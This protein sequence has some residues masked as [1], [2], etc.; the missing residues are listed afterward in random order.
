MEKILEQK[1]LPIILPEDLSL[2]DFLAPSLN[3]R[4]RVT[5]RL[6]SYRDP[7]GCS[8]NDWIESYQAQIITPSDHKIAFTTTKTGREDAREDYLG[9]LDVINKGEYVF[10]INVQCSFKP[11]KSD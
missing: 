3:L 9:L 6:V 2:P 11:S 4:P 10:S 5:V 8:G 1:T 7:I